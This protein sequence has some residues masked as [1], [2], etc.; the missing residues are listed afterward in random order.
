MM[1]TD[2]IKI[3]D[4]TALNQVFNGKQLKLSDGDVV[5]GKILQVSSGTV[6]LTMAGETIQAKLEGAPPSVGWWLFQVNVDAQEQIS[7]RIIS[8]LPQPD[9][10]EAS[11]QLQNITFDPQVFLR[12]GLPLSKEN[13]L[14]FF[15]LMEQFQAKYGVLPDPKAVALLIARDWPNTPGTMLSAWI[16]QDPQ[17]RNQLWNT[18]SD[19]SLLGQTVRMNDPPEAVFNQLTKME[20]GIFQTLFRDSSG[21]GDLGP[22]VGQQAIGPQMPAVAEEHPTVSPAADSEQETSSMPFAQLFKGIR[23]SSS[24]NRPT[25]P[26]GANEFRSGIPAAMNN[27]LDPPAVPVANAAPPESVIPGESPRDIQTFVMQLL[28]RTSIPGN[29]QDPGSAVPVPKAPDQAAAVQLLMSPMAPDG[30]VSLPGLSPNE[31]LE[32]I[33]IQFLKNRSESSVTDPERP[34][35]KASFSEKADLELAL[36]ALT[37]TLM[38]GEGGV[39]AQGLGQKDTVEKV[40]TQLFKFFQSDAPADSEN[41][42]I[43]PVEVKTSEPEAAAVFQENYPASRQ[44]TPIQEGSLKQVPP[45]READPNSLKMFQNEVS[46]ETGADKQGPIRTVAEKEQI[47]SLLQQ[48]NTVLQK[49]ATPQESGNLL[50]IIPLLVMD[51]RKNIYELNVEWQREY[52]PER[53]PEESE[54]RIRV[55][56]PTENMG[57]IGLNV[58]MSRQKIKIH[59]EVGSNAVRQFFMQNLSLLRTT[60]Q[61]RGRI[62]IAV[63]VRQEPI[64]HSGNGVDLRL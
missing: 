17:L 23:E 16:A 19:D 2:V 34:A 35:A 52:G 6:K 61:E 8:A 22:K 44:K 60:V 20:Q 37:P 33:L 9:L 41:K 18:I 13:I 50:N 1:K 53:A 43:I 30:K 46:Q 38:A 25:L 64:D 26:Q 11:P 5:A 55:A 36:Q 15:E 45:S 47:L 51:S 14:K 12:Q 63:T 7:L 39:P 29:P 27:R 40:L 3:S 21:M 49:L 58:T 31:D 24:Q 48:N 59:F 54:E 42:P 62:G 32:T 28:N 57:E 10:N 56:I 4:L